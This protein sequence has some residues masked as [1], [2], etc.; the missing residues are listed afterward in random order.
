MNHSP[1]LLSLLQD[2]AIC[3]GLLFLIALCSWAAVKLSQKRPAL[4]PPAT[5]ADEDADALP[6]GP[7]PRD[8]D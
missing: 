2:T 5:D 6:F 7:A 4:M 1:S 8:S 3:V